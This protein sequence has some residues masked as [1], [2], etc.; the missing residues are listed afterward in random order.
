[1]QICYIPIKNEYQVYAE[2]KLSKELSKVKDHNTRNR[3][4]AC[5]ML[6]AANSIKTLAEEV[7]KETAD[8]AED[9]AIDVFEASLNEAGGKVL[10]LIQVTGYWYAIF[11]AGIQVIR[12]VHN[13]DISGIVTII[14]K[15]ALMYSVLH[16]LPWIFRTIASLFPAV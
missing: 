15:Y 9:L 14:V 4:I 5:V 16:M 11:A 8:K 13:E 2:R 3:L 10:R 6:I 7:A 12:H 1:M